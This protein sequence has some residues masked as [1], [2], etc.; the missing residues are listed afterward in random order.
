MNFIEEIKVRLVERRV[1]VQFLEIDNYPIIIHRHSGQGIILV[2]IDATSLSEAQKEGER[3]KEVRNKLINCTD[4]I[5]NAFRT[6]NEI[7]ITKT[8]CSETK[9]SETESEETG[10]A[11]YREK[12]PIIISED[13]YRQSP[14]VIFSRIL[15]HLGVFHSIFARNCEVRKIDKK[16][17]NSFLNENHSYGSCTSRYNYGLFTKKADANYPENSLIA[18][19]SFSNSRRWKKEEKIIRSHEWLRYSSLPG[20]R[21]SGGMGKLLKHFI[22][23]VKPDDI[24]SYADLEWSDGNVYRALGFKDCGEREALNFIILPPSW[25]RVAISDESYELSSQNTELSAKNTEPLMG[26]QG[27]FYQNFGSRKYRL[28]LGEYDAW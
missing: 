3:V 7:E 21:I 27:L 22:D 4:S 12:Y 26:K 1:D 9:S 2:G 5:C 17:A 23:E 24:M 13:R 11:N 28:K 20:I 10:H 16:L 14:E 19:A 8:K 25:V 6:E 15:A 18:V